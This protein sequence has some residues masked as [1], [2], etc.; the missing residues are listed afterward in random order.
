MAE[1]RPSRMRI[2]LGPPWNTTKCEKGI[3]DYFYPRNR[4]PEQTASLKPPIPHLPEEIKLAIYSQLYDRYE[5]QGRAVC[6]HRNKF[7]IMFSQPRLWAHIVAFQICSE[8]RREAIQRY[9]QP[10]EDQLPFC[11]ETDMIRIQLDI[12]LLFRQTQ[13]GIQEALASPYTFD[14]YFCPKKPEHYC[15]LPLAAKQLD[16]DNLAGL[17]H[18][19]YIA[20]DV[21][22]VSELMLL[23]SLLQFLP[24][25]TKVRHV[26]FRMMQLD[27]GEVNNKRVKLLAT[28]FRLAGLSH[29]VELL[30]LEIS[31]V[32]WPPW[33]DQ[34]G[35]P[36][37]VIDWAAHT[38]NSTIP[39]VQG[40]A[41]A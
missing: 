38:E 19:E 7:G 27:D 31:K 37:S 17:Q 28:T 24:R 12:P 29:S 20:K 10:T 16:T 40:A 6:L 11:A 30:K 15:N 26:R 2:R 33:A 23:W 41:A 21:L 18:I 35:Q 36:G 22:R 39:T 8:T 4:L 13:F 25:T 5:L 14:I 1:I 34:E 32:Q 3:R 9:G